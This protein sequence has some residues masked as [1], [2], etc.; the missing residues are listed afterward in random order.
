MSENS[1]SNNYYIVHNNIRMKYDFMSII[2]SL[3]LDL[4]ERRAFGESLAAS[5]EPLGEF[6]QIQCEQDK[7]RQ[8]T[9]SPTLTSSTHQMIVLGERLDVL[10]RRETNLWDRHSAEW[11]GRIRELASGVADADFKK[12]VVDTLYVDD[13]IA[14]AQNIDTIVQLLPSARRVSFRR[15]DGV[16]ESL[17]EM[18]IRKLSAASSL[19][20]FEAIEFTGW[21]GRIVSTALAASPHLSGLQQLSI[22]DCNLNSTGAAAILQSE[23]LSGLR[24][25]DLSHNPI[26]PT[27]TQAI[28]S[29]PLTQ[30]ET[31]RLLDTGIG[32]AWAMALGKAATLR[33]LRRLDVSDNQLSSDAICSLL[34]A[35][36]MRNVTVD[37]STDHLSSTTA[38]AVRKKISAHNSSGQGSNV[39]RQ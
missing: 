39:D 37:V 23:H 33:S 17:Q 15:P 16:P 14:F 26:G 5:G 12:G 21:N 4:A 32:D 10:R 35:P 25:L 19:A 1:G 36:A 11:V 2:N 29:S 18:A 3:P 30:L 7:L 34:D 38:V 27:G 20:H 13:A 28:D 24:W 22:V 31:L 9:R 8:M 6:I